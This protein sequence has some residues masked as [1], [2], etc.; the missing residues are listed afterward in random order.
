MWLI[1]SNGQYEP[2]FWN[3]KLS[4]QSSKSIWRWDFRKFGRFS[5]ENRC[6]KQISNW[7]NANC[8]DG[9]RSVSIGFDR[10][11]RESLY[12]HRS[13]TVASMT[14]WMVRNGAC[15]PNHVAE[16]RDKML[17]NSECSTESRPSSVVVW[18]GLQRFGTL[19]PTS[20]WFSIQ[21]AFYQSATAQPQMLKVSP[22]HCLSK[23]HLKSMSQN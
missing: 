14:V 8:D 7:A 13:R 18:I 16:I 15:A 17:L 9:A 22:M 2:L 5:A 6:A 23:F 4:F 3:G 10:W 1:E 19:P 11:Q 20:H 12:D 21:Q